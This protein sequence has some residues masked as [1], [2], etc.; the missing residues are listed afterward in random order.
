MI[1]N[2][3][4]DKSG[5]LESPKIATVRKLSTNVSIVG[6]ELLRAF[7]RLFYLQVVSEKTL[8]SQGFTSNL[9]HILYENNRSYNFY[10]SSY[11]F[12]FILFLSFLKNQKQESGFQQVGGLVTR[13]P[14]RIQ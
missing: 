6:E 12:A 1:K 14:C 3:L 8:G 7:Y 2:T 9:R 10:R 5:N 13:K 4:P 11:K